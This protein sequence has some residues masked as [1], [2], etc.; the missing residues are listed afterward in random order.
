MLSAHHSDAIGA[1]RMRARG[2]L[3][4]WRCDG[5]TAPKYPSPARSEASLGGRVGRAEAEAGV[6]LPHVR[7]A[8]CGTPTRPAARAGHPPR[9][10][11]GK[12]GTLPGRE[13]RALEASRSMS[14]FTSGDLIAFHQR[15]HLGLVLVGGAHGDVVA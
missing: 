8:A 11:G 13:D 2:S 14:A 5:A 1:A 7:G 10:G 4:F 6:R 12:E 9:K 3:K 15:L